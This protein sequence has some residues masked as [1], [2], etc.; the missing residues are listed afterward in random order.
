MVFL[1]LIVR[2][3]LIAALYYGDNLNAQ[4]GKWLANYD[5]AMEYNVPIQE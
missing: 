1:F 3:L 4:S 2:K 5:I